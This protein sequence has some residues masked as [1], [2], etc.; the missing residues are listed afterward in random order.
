MRSI[1]QS[2]RKIVLYFNGANHFSHFRFD[3]VCS[4]RGGQWLPAFQKCVLGH[5]NPTTVGYGDISPMTDLGQAIATLI[6]VLGYSIV[7]PYRLCF[8][9]DCDQQ[10]ATCM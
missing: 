4:G 1:R 8:R 7:V 2:F 10:E 3:Y 6:M 5:C 9:F